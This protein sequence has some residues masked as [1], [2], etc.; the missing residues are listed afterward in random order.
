M[1][2][3]IIDLNVDNKELYHDSVIRQNENRASQLIIPIIDEFTGYD[4]SLSFKLND[5]VIYTT[6][7]LEAVDEKI[8]FEITN[9]LTFEPGKLLVELNAYDTNVLVK[10]AIIPLQVIKALGDEV[11][12]IPESYVAYMELI[13]N[14]MDKTIYD[15]DEVGGDVFD[16]DNMEQGVIN[17]YVDSTEKLKLTGKYDDL[18]RQTIPLRWLLDS[19]LKWIRSVVQTL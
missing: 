16:M 10:S 19:M 13:D 15:P 11:I 14:Y 9:V 5:H 17:H 18:P 8:T 1:R 2:D 3:I 7:M 12:I 6:G 4:C